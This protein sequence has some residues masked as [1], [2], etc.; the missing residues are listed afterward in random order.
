MM[1]VATFNMFFGNYQ[2]DMIFC[3]NYERYDAHLF[4]EELYH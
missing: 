2:N 1:N 3:R 4:K